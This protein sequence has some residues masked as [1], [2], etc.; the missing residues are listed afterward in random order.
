MHDQNSGSEDNNIVN[1]SEAQDSESTKYFNY[2]VQKDFVLEDIRMAKR[3]R[4]GVLYIFLLVLLFIA[5]L[6]PTYMHLTDISGKSVFAQLQYMDALSSDSEGENAIV[7]S[8]GTKY[9][10]SIGDSEKG[11]ISYKIYIDNLSFTE[12]RDA[13]KLMGGELLTIADEE[14]YEKILGLMEGSTAKFFWFG[15]YKDKENNYISL[16]GET[17]SFF[18]WKQGDPISDRIMLGDRDYLIFFKNED[19]EWV[20]NFIAND[21][22]AFAPELFKGN[23]AYICKISPKESE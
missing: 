15:I 21:P 10:A 4:L 23:I 7:K 12:A 14:E 13:C 19:G 16:S 20:F 11:E 5:S 1:T 17:P 3:R 9:Q 18:P 6:Y 2:K 22:T 8:E